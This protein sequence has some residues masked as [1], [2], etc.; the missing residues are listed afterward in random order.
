MLGLL[1]LSVRISANK[2]LLLLLQSSMNVRLDTRGATAAENARWNTSSVTARMTVSPEPTRIRQS[3]VRSNHVCELLP[4][5]TATK[6][7]STY[8]GPIS[9]KFGRHISVVAVL[10]A[11]VEISR[12]GKG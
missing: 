5:K 2:I 7:L 1:C 10:S 4:D 6:C 8:F 9:M 12:A 11:D 3:V